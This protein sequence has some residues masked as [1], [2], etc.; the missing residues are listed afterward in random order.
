MRVLLVILAVLVIAFA[1]ASGVLAETTA[2]VQVVMVPEV[3]GGI[4]NFT[5]T[6]VSD[7][8]MLLEWSFLG[9]AVNILVRSKYGSYPDDVIDMYTTP[10]DGNLVYYG[11]AT[12]FHDTSMD[13]DN[14]A[15][16]LYYK[17]W[18]QHPDG[19]WYIATSTGWE[20]S[21]EV[22][23]IGLILVAVCLTAFVFVW[24]SL[25]LA[26]AGM[27][28]WLG[29]A[30]WVALGG[31]SGLPMSS[32][33]TVIVVAVFVLMAF[34]PLIRYISMLGKAKITTTD[35]KTGKSYSMWGKVP[36]AS[37]RS[38]SQEAQDSWKKTLRGITK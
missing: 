3:T 13:F 2:T 33:Y 27:L 10:T 20:E 38:R 35:A 17:A 30:A 26:L 19:T 11:D 23:F 16:P 9:D 29:L 7:Y 28:G 18:A 5:I 31:S 14:N 4:G 34:T 21:K 25:P 12:S 32:T 8:D 36:K 37:T 1:P 24:N 22:L 15:G 6:Y